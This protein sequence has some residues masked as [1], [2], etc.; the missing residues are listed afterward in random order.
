MFKQIFTNLSIYQKV[1]YIFLIL[2]SLLV[3]QAKVFAQQTGSISGKITDKSNNE[4]LIG[5][6]VLIVGTTIGASTDI[7]GT[8]NIKNLSEGNY[9]IKVSY[10]SYNSVTVNN[11][12]VKPGVS[13]NIDIALESTATELQE[14]LVTAEALKNTEANVLKIQKNSSS[15]VDGVSSELIKKNNSSDGADILKRMTGVTISEG[16]YAFIRRQFTKH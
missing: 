10:I 16:K 9:T 6:N 11:V 4:E 3:L 15:I 1:K 2:F 8:F 12:V 5:A 14:V 13:T 7:D